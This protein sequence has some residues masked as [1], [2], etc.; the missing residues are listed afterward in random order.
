[1]ERSLHELLDLDEPNSGLSHAKFREVSEVVLRL[2][3]QRQNP[4]AEMRAAAAQLNAA[5][6]GMAAV[7]GKLERAYQAG[8]DAQRAKVAPFYIRVL[9][10]MGR[11]AEAFEVIRAARGMHLSE[12]FDF[13]AIAGALSKHG[14]FADSARW[15]TKGLV[16]HVGSLAEIGLDDMLG[17]D[18][19][20]ALARGRRTARH[21]LGVAPD[22]LDELYDHYQAI[23]TPGKPDE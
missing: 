9:F 11:E 2:I 17:D 19:T 15:Y 18:G 20:A 16:Q 7:E 21:A 10:D 13:A 4:S 23:A 22:H 3:E 1:M 14:H 6:G 8:D 12:P 5:L